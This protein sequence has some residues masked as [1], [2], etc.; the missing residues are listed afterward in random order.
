MFR[1]QERA[2]EFVPGGGNR[3][4]CVTRGQVSRLRVAPAI[5]ICVYACMRLTSRTR[6]RWRVPGECVG[7]QATKRSRAPRSVP[8]CALPILKNPA[9]P[10][11]PVLHQLTTFNKLL[12]SP[13]YSPLRPSAR[14]IVRIASNESIKR[15]RIHESKSTDEHR[16]PPYLHRL[17]AIAW[18]LSLTLIRI[19]QF[20]RA[21]PCN[22][23][24]P[25]QDV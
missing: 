20:R 1:F 24:P 18:V 21:H 12:V 2:N 3:V 15:A 4:G 6:F 17:D 23:H 9:I 7:G 10:A 11:I 16:H 14:M 22:L 5:W 19:S 8:A 13:L 25:P